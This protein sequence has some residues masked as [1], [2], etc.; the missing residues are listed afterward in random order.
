MGEKLQTMRLD[1]SCGRRI[2]PGEE[3]DPKISLGAHCC[4]FHRKKCFFGDS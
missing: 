2:A 4:D 3:K 1:S